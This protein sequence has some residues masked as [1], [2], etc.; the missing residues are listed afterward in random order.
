MQ[1]TPRASGRGRQRSCRG[2]HPCGRCDARPGSECA[3]CRSLSRLGV[4]R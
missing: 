4:I 2:N 3:R 1:H